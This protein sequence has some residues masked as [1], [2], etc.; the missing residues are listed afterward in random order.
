MTFRFADF[1]LDADRFVLRRAGETLR[2][3]PKVFDLL[4]HLLRH[5]ARVVPREELV[6]VLWGGTVVGA[7]SLSGLVNELRRALGERGDDRSSIRT[8][9]AR[10]YQFVAGVSE[11]APPPLATGGATPRAAPDAGLPV[12]GDGLL[13]RVRLRLAESD[14]IGGFGFLVEGP[15]G[16]GRTVLLERAIGLALAAGFDVERID[17]GGG[18]GPSLPERLLEGLVARRGLG[19]IRADWPDG[20]AELLERWLRGE[21]RAGP[22][23]DALARALAGLLG[24]LARHSPLLLAV[25]DLDGGDA[26]AFELIHG[27]LSTSPETRIGV[28]ATR[29]E[30]RGTGPERIGPPAPGA[31]WW[32]HPRVEVLRTGRLGS[33]GLRAILAAEGVPP[34]PEPLVE[35]LLGHLASRRRGHDRVARWLAGEA[36]AIAAEPERPAMRRVEAPREPGRASGVCGPG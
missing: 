16:S 3:R 29:L 19:A 36:E 30:A 27:L 10:G 15:R 6:D 14:A 13:E 26:S 11:Q 8:V 24:R 4:L 12:L 7:G 33:R 31:D 17:L 9:H 35:A 2:L 32:R 34:I 1:E 21:R 25:D 20:Q 18:A 5:R 23:E 22:G 28:L